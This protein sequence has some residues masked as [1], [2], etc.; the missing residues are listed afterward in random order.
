[1]LLGKMVVMSRGGAENDRG[2]IV[3]VLLPRGAL[4][5][6]ST[7]V[8]QI[9]PSACAVRLD[10][11]HLTPYSSIDPLLIVLSRSSTS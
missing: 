10:H 5:G 2:E 11:D 3:E 1:M 4:G 8:L 9:T 7:S 6:L